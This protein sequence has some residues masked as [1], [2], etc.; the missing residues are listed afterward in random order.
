MRSKTVLKKI[1]NYKN[2][3]LPTKSHKTKA[4]L[5]LVRAQSLGYKNKPD[6]QSYTL[7]IKKGN[8]NL[9]QTK[10]GRKPVNQCKKISRDISKKKILLERFSKLHKNLKIIG[11]YILKKDK[12]RIYYQVISTIKK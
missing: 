7:S 5:K 2:I 12:N 10:K 9:I 6:F 4:P 3:K 1:L 8:P 11:A